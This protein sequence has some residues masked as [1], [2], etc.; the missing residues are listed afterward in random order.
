M[1]KKAI[2]VLANMKKIK[3]KIKYIKIKDLDIEFQVP[4]KYYG[5]FS[6][7]EQ[8]LKEGYFKSLFSKSRSFNFDLDVIPEYEIEYGKLIIR[9]KLEEF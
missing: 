1:F 8:S 2:L 6:T 4:L 7:Q 3:I 5:Y 9:T